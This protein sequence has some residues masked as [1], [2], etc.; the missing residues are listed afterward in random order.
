M[1]EQHQNHEDD[2]PNHGHAPNPQRDDVRRVD[3]ARQ[4]PEERLP[5]IN[6]RAAGGGDGARRRGGDHERSPRLGGFPPGLS[7]R[8]A[9]RL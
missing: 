7:W 3:E 6:A 8:L 1:E 2:D 9:S 4:P 5:P